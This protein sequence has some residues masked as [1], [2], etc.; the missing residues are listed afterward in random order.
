MS[1]HAGSLGYPL[2]SIRVL[3]LSRA[4]SGPYVGRI[5]G[6]LGASVVKVE[7]P[8]GD[9]SQAFGVSDA[10]HSGLYVQMNAGK[11]N[12]SLD[13]RTDGGVSLFRRLVGE[14]DVLVNNYR[15]GV[16]DRLGV[17]WQRLA[18]LNPGLIMLSISGFGQTGPEAKRPAY[19]PVL[20]AESGL[21]AR[22][23]EMDRR[24]ATDLPLALADSLA[25][26]H[27]AIAVL[28]ALRLRDDTRV[29]QHIDLSM[30]EA[31]LASDDYVHYSL[32]ANGPPVEGRGVTYPHPQ[33]DVLIAGEPR[34][35]WMSLRDSAGLTDP[36]EFLPDE[37]KFAARARVVREWVLAFQDR[38]DLFEQLENATLAWAVVKSTDEAVA[39]SSAVERGIAVPVDDRRG[40]TR[41]VVR[42]PYRFSDAASG[43]RAGAAFVGEH[44]EEVLVEWLGLDQAELESLRASGVLRDSEPPSR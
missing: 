17:G 38:R 37:D 1:D 30:F 21:L 13:L 16:M 23:A 28:A 4:V 42:M 40:G 9:V 26:L 25:G 5:L 14:C 7:L 22:M 18:E 44:T 2:A 43:P 3:D 32:E 35:I 34:H 27:G 24:E 10:P 36:S 33:G 15:P 39:S 29:G 6:D 41:P 8:G 31:M 12:I 19:A 11:R 20:H